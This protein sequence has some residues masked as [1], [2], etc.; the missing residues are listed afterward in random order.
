[1]F[2]KQ[3]NAYEATPLR[4]YWLRPNGSAQLGNGSTITIWF[5]S[6]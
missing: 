6:S 5:A 1:M 2:T 3:I 4:R